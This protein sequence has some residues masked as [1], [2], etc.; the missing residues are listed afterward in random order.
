MEVSLHSFI[1]IALLSILPSLVWLASYLREDIHPE[2]RKI[3]FQ[4]FLVGFLLPPFVA[5]GE[6]LLQKQAD[7][8]SK[9]PLALAV[10]VIMAAL[11]E[12][13][14]KYLAARAVFH[15]EK[16]FDELTDG[17]IYLIIV[18]LGFA[19]SENII[20]LLSAAHE[21]AQNILALLGLRMIGA[22]LLHTFS[23]GM[24]GYFL[25][26]G[27]FLRERF[28]IVKGLAS[29]TAIHSLFN[30]FVLHASKD[31]L[32]FV[33]LAVMVLAAGLAIVLKDFYNL[34]RYDQH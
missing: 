12:E 19:A 3:I 25:A 34:R 21:P 24:M 1:V 22:N 17:M 30:W 10:V 4:L 2:P 5:F 20:I 32:Y 9:A 6:V 31:S 13:A 14:T 16:E 29:A 28:S 8:I 7:T 11:W 15:H 27:L 26:R 18:A 23:S 33:V